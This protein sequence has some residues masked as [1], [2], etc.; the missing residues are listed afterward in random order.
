[1]VDVHTRQAKAALPPG[2]SL[3]DVGQ[4]AEVMLTPDETKD[5][6]EVADMMPMLDAILA[7]ASDTLGP[8]SVSKMLREKADLIEMISTRRMH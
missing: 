7:M 2:V 1:M 4:E 3:G 5:R 8:K 6:E